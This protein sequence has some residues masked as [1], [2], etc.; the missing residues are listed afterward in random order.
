MVTF[1]TSVPTCRESDF[2]AFQ[3]LQ[4][5]KEGD[6]GIRL[7]TNPFWLPDFHWAPGFPSHSSSEENGRVIA[8]KK[9][10][11]CVQDS[12]LFASSEAVD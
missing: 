5:S 6:E 8:C 3:I 1:Q 11:I 7:E 12:G 9:F 4:S 10:L 2:G